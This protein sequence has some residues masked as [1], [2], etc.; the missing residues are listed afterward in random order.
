MKNTNNTRETGSQIT[1]ADSFLAGQLDCRNGE[2][3][4]LNM[5][6][7]YYRGYSTQYQAI[8]NATNMSTLQNDFDRIF[9]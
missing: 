8:E 2:E 1:D 4:K 3:A 6:N 5:E 9:K 7:D